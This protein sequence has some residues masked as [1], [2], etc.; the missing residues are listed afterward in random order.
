MSAYKERMYIT[1]SFSYQK[2]QIENIN[3]TERRTSKAA[4]SRKMNTM[5]FE[6]KKGLTLLVYF[7]ISRK[8]KCRSAV[9][10]LS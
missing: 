3:G 7:S 1:D 6:T 2:N 4:T 5:L 9:S 8:T 10:V